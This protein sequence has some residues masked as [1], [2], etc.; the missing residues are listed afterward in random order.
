MRELTHCLLGSAVT[1]HNY[2]FYSSSLVG[3]L[4]SKGSTVQ[5]HEG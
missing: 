3:A 5:Y 2:G 4:A 1:F